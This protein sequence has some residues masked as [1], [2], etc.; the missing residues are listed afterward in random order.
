MLIAQKPAILVELVFIEQTIRFVIV[1]TSS[2]GV[3]FRTLLGT[4]TKARRESNVE[5]NSSHFSRVVDSKNHKS[6]FRISTPRITKS[7][8]IN[9]DP[10]KRLQYFCFSDYIRD[11]LITKSDKIFNTFYLLLPLIHL[12]YTLFLEKIT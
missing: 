5:S 4:S 8:I 6:C 11:S 10:P 12:I 2:E 1:P 3:F 7:R 9:C